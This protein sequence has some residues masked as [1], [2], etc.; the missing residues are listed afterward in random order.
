MTALL[1]ASA[2][3]VAVIGC[4]VLGPLPSAGRMSPTAPL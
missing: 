2:L 1:I 3:L 4:A